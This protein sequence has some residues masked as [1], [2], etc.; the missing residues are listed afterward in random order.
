MVFCYFFLSYKIY[1]GKKMNL[2]QHHKKYEN[3]YSSSHKI[4]ME[5]IDEQA[6]DYIIKSLGDQFRDLINSGCKSNDDF[7]S[8]PNTKA[9]INNIDNFIFER[10]GIRVKHVKSKG[11]PYACFPVA[12]N[13]TNV[14]NRE[15]ESETKLIEKCLREYESEFGKVDEGKL[16]NDAYDDIGVI[17]KRLVTNR[18]ALTEYLKSDSIYIDLRKAKVSNL[19]SDYLV[20]VLSDF[21]MLINIYKLNEFEIVAVLLHELGHIFTHLEY[22]YRV[23]N[24]TQVLVDTV[25]DVVMKQNNSTKENLRL[26]YEKATKT[27]VS[28]EFNKMN[29]MT[30]AIYVGK[31]ILNRTISA[32]DH[33]FTDSEQL[34]DQFAGKF[35]MSGYLVTALDKL[36]GLDTPLTYMRSLWYMSQGELY[37]MVI[38]SIII[39]CF[40]MGAGLILIPIYLALHTTLITWLTLFRKSIASE[41][42]LTEGMTYDD[43]KRRFSRNK[44]ELVRQ[45]AL[46]KLPKELEKEIV[47]GIKTIEKSMAKVPDAHNGL[48]D[49][50][51]LL[52]SDDRKFVINSKRTEQVLEDIISNDVHIGRA[53]VKDLI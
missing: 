4:S 2:F 7:Y 30:A 3:E 42:T 13:Q 36:H 33:S 9:A 37:T 12:P 50:F 16:A 25:K 46:A 23:A 41:E 45:L 27:K 40:T 39:G 43:I 29:T 51:F 8:E 14:L 31:G 6:N 18:K 32:Q 28:P 38:L 49:K 34:A 5:M 20:Y 35:G 44:N 52:F 22:S 24:T 10:F 11:I 47:N 19:P 17:Y 48:I 53:L 15:I 26:V 21:H 1:K